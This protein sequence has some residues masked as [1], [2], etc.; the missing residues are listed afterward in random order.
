[1]DLS[2]LGGA[3][4][5]DRTDKERV[6]A[7]TVAVVGVMALDLLCGRQ[8]SDQDDH[9]GLWRQDRREGFGGRARSAEDAA[10]E[11][12]RPCQ[13][14]R[15]DQPPGRGALP[16]LAR[17]RQPAPVHDPPGGNP[18]AGRQAFALEGQGA[19]RLHLRMGCGNHGGP[20]QRAARLGVGARVKRSQRRLGELQA[21]AGRPGH[22]GRGR[23]AGRSSRR[24]HRGARSPS[25][26]AR[27]RAS[28]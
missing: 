15:H 21:K 26:S 16:L 28:R 5:S 6:A 9:D 19:R 12:R 10:M 4:A 14:E 24:R 1:M 23:D 22:G 8:L 18:E 3:W 7:A 25:C 11:R 20:A 13:E 27:N 17:F 2:L